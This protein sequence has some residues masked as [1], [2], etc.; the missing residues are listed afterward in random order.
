MFN[1]DEDDRDEVS[2][3]HNDLIAL[4]KTAGTYYQN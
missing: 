4:A 1:M 2:Q 3:I